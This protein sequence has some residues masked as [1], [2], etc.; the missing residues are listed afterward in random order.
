MKLSEFDYHL[1]EE[2]IAQTPLKKRDTSRLMVLD[3]KNETI[4]DKHFYD[5]LDYLYEG[6]ILVRNNTKVIPARLYGTKEE[7]N[8]HVEVLLLK[9]YSYW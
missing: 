5:I 1:P 4:E 6:D 8:G 7:T 2:L 3:R 9:D